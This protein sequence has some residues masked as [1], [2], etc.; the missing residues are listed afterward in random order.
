METIKQIGCSE[1]KPNV[2]IKSNE[3]NAPVSFHLQNIEYNFLQF[4]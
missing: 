3:L 4:S 2:G 1:G